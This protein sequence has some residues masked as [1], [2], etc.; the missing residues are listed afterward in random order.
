MNL[1]DLTGKVAI[2]TGGNSG[3]GLGMARGLAAAGAGIVIVARDAA[4]SNAAVAQLEAAGG[5][6]LAVSCDVTDPVSIE[7]MVQAAHAWRGRIDILVNN[8]GT[9]MRKRPEDL[10]LDAWHGVLST[11]LDSA[12]LC[13]KACYPIMKAQGGG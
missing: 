3:I 13:S 9:T 5:A 12:F 7:A 11:N 1:F 10:S 2:V 6:A 8:A 4:R